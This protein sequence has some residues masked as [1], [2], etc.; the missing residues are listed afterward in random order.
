MARFQ[1]RR[2]WGA[3]TTV[4]VLAAGLVPGGGGCS[5]ASIGCRLRLA[6]DRARWL[7]GKH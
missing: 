6:V 4:P 2:Q 3:G 7:G 5:V 1:L